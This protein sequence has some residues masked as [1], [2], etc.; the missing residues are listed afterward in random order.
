MYHIQW[1]KPNN[2]EAFDLDHYELRVGNH[3]TNI[4]AKEN[5]VIVSL[6]MKKEIVMVANIVAVDRCGKKS[7]SSSKDIPS[8]GLPKPGGLGNTTGTI[9]CKMSCANEIIIVTLPV[10]VMAVIIGIIISVVLTWRLCSW[11]LQQNDHDH[12][13]I[14]CT[15]QI[16]TKVCKIKSMISILFV[17]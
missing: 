3:T 9:I 14:E 6:I 10:T 15:S 11:R 2:T 1:A 8:S 7:N 5:A 17:S 16:D 4:D 12:C 13:P